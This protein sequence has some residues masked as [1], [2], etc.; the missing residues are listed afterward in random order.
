ME[1]CV[2]LYKR[3]VKKGRLISEIFNIFLISFLMMR[4]SIYVIQYINNSILLLFNIFITKHCYI[5]IIWIHDDLNFKLDKDYDLKISCFWEEP[6]ARSIMC[7]E[8]S[9]P[10]RCKPL[11]KFFTRKGG[12]HLHKFDPFGLMIDPELR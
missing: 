4:C 9:D 5:V 7:L 1:K 6:S 3:K 2:S 12:L 11:L 10:R 8:G